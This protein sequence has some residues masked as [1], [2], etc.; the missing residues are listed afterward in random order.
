MARKHIPLI[1]L[2]G[3]PIRLDLSWFFILL[4]FSWS[5]TTY[6]FPEKYRG[7]DQ[8]TYWIMGFSGALLLFFSVLLH[9][10]GHSLVGRRY[11]VNI[12]SITLFIFGG[13]AD[14]SEEPLGPKEEFFMAI[15]GPMV[16]LVLAGVFYS[17]SLLFVQIIP[18]QIPLIAVMSY[19]ALAN[20]FLAIFNL[21][22]GFPLD[23][24]RVLRAAIWKTTGSLNRATRIASSVGKGFGLV[25]MGLGILNIIGGYFVSG[26]WIMFIGMFLRTAAQASYTN[27]FVKQGLEGMSVRDFMTE[28]LVTV[29]KDMSLEQA[30]QGYFLLHPYHIYPVIEDGHAVGFVDT[31]SVK[32]IPHQ[33]WPNTQIGEIAETNL[34]DL[35]V[36]PEDDAVKALSTMA[37]NKIGRLPVVSD[38]GLVGLISRRDILE[39]I[40][41]RAD[42]SE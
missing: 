24:G 9:E 17:T 22:P 16:S 37:Q 13:L 31:N 5:L 3:I 18:K 23:G 34:F 1:T 10:L 2:F 39:M 42:L 41:L 21:L 30:V 26:L 40:K 15:A 14:M 28:D 7:L 20:T 8:T 12:K 32:Q 27:L 33:Q 19:L 35:A 38:S 36:H 29:P 25:L 6:F 11:G 4:F